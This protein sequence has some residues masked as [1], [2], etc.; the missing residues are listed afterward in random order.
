MTCDTFHEGI[1]YGTHV[2]GLLVLLF[3]AASPR[4]LNTEKAKGSC[5]PL[6][7]TEIYC[8]IVSDFPEFLYRIVINGSAPL[9]KYNERFMMSC[10]IEQNIGFPGAGIIDFISAND[11][12]VGNALIIHI[13]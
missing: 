4:L 5:I 6:P 11:H 9:C 8:G 1:G 3:P 7:I 2:A 10:L 12:D 13:A